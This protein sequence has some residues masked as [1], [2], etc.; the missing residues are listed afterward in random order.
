MS[1]TKVRI[2]YGQGE[3]KTSSAIGLCIKE[4]SLGRRVI[5]I[6]FLKGKGL[7]EV[8]F[9]NRLEPEIKLF[10]FEKEEEGYCNLSDEEKNEEKRNIINGF[11]FAKKV[12][13][14]R[15]CDLLVLDEVLG[16]LDLEIISKEELISLI[17]LKEEDF[18][19]IL[20]GKKLPDELISHADVVTEFRTVKE[21]NEWIIM[22][23][24]WILSWQ[25]D[26]TMLV[27]TK[28]GRGALYK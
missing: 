17:E 7:E 16:L 20:T 11:N 12:I 26:Y 2:Y 28:I 23:R 24:I 25:T 1:N 13:E 8:K 10:R 5:I 15:E 4:A 6:Q 19:L 18:G 3:G 21:N 27:Y 9:L 22:K 14:T